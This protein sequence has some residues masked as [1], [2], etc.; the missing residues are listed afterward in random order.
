MVQQGVVTKKMRHLDG[1]RVSHPVLMISP[2]EQLCSNL[3]NKKLHKWHSSFFLESRFNTTISYSVAL[4]LSLFIAYK[5]SFTR[6]LPITGWAAGNAV[7]K[8]RHHIL[9]SGFVR[10]HRGGRASKDVR[11]F[12]WLNPLLALFSC[13]FGKNSRINTF[14]SLHVEGGLKEN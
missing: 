5:L 6:C 14:L 9:S 10:P 8:C 13:G 12:H 7:S 2:N 1:L 4:Q 3:I 11:K